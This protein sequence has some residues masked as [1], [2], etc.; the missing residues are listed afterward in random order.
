[1]PLALKGRALLRR[2]QTPKALGDEYHGLHAITSVNR[3]LDALTQAPWEERIRNNRKVAEE[4]ARR[5]YR[6]REEDAGPMAPCGPEEQ[7]VFCG[8]IILGNLLLVKELHE[9]G[10]PPPSVH[11]WVP[12]FGRPLSLA[13]GW[14]H[15][16]IVRYL[17]ACGADPR[18]V[19]YKNPA[20]K[21]EEWDPN[22]NVTIGIYKYSG[23]AAYADY[24]EGGPLR[25]AVAGGH[26]EIVRLLLSPE[27]RVSVSKAEFFRVMAAAAHAGRMRILQLLDSALIETTGRSWPHYPK[28]G[29]SLLLEAAHGG[30]EDIVEMLLDHGV[31]VDASPYTPEPGEEWPGDEL[32]KGTALW[33]AAKMGRISIVRMLLDRGAD[34]H[35][36]GDG[37]HVAAQQGHVD[38]LDLL[39]ERSSNPKKGEIISESF[40]VAICFGQVDLAKTVLERHPE[41]LEERPLLGHLINAIAYKDPAMI[42]MLVDAG[43]PL[44]DDFPV[45]WLP[46]VAAKHYGGQW[47]AD[48]L[49][50][51]G[52]QDRDWVGDRG[53]GSMADESDV[54]I[55]RSRGPVLITQRTWQW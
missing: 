41:V 55:L 21:D 8:A 37:F 38:I 15:L 20:E 47:L 10:Q 3:A 48:Y 46:I 22:M 19:N 13:A 4:V 26:E 45:E 16:D 11:D 49:I 17:L 43:A 7:M 52:A 25:A 54:K 28:L 51:I 31:E 18:V 23:Y 39:F 12:Y 9:N 30:H 32:S 36:S 34:V 24:A 53:F 50:S 1:M 40:G 35:E 33:N 29:G 42:S 14:G 5:Y 2:A 6:H 27:H 44:N